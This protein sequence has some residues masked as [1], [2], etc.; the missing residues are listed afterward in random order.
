M[1]SRDSWCL[2]LSVFIARQ[3]GRQGGLRLYDFVYGSVGA[4]GIWLALVR[5]NLHIMG[6]SLEAENSFQL[7][8]PS[9]FGPNE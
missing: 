3:M 5:D 4:G 7:S 6:A 8:Y 1:I 2:S 9:I